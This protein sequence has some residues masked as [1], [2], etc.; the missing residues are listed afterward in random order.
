MPQREKEKETC[1]EILNVAMLGKGLGERKARP[2]YL[3]EP[4]KVLEREL[5][6]RALQGK[7]TKAS[8]ST[9][10]RS[11][12]MECQKMVQGVGEHGGE[13]HEIGVVWM[14]AEVTEEKMLK[15]KGK[16]KDR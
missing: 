7:D 12:T 9:A 16:L 13:D 14:I 10:V 3:K 5:E 6:G 2:E 4:G 15:K 1:G 8:A 11:G